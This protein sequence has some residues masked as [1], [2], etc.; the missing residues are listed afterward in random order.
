M[1]A[2]PRSRRL[3][4]LS[5]SLFLR[6]SRFLPASLQIFRLAGLAML[7]TTL[8]AAAALAHTGTSRPPLPPRA[9]STLR[10]LPAVSAAAPPSGSDK[11]SLLR[12]QSHPLDP[13]DPVEGLAGIL[14]QFGTSVLGIEMNEPCAQPCL[15]GWKDGVEVRRG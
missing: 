1:S 14:L 3:A 11:N 10:P 7:A 12:R 9:I 5:L 8:F 2:S 15:R 6:S 4:S 13:N